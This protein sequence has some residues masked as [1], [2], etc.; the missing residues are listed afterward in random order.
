ME[1]GC[2]K[3]EAGVLQVVYT[4]EVGTEDDLVDVVPAQDQ[5]GCV[6]KLE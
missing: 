2:E 6:G 4:Q 5:L 3:A 1:L